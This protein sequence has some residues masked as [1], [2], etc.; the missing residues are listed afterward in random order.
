MPLRLL[1]AGEGEWKKQAAGDKAAM[2]P[3]TDTAGRPN[4]VAQFDLAAA[5][6]LGP[7]WV[8]SAAPVLYPSVAEGLGLSRGDPEGLLS[9]LE[10][11]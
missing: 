1:P 10:R 8:W 2:P 7:D 3:A 4:P 9:W 5:P 11:H 6:D